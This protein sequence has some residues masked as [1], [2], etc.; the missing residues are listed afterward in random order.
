MSITLKSSHK[1]TYAI[2]SDSDAHTLL[3]AVEDHAN[4][5]RLWADHDERGRH[6]R[7]IRA[8][9]VALGYPVDPE[10]EVAS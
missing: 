3:I 1:W 8:L 10:E 9:N 4:R 2:V 5:R 7:I 6:Q